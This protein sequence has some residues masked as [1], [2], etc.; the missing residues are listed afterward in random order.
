[1]KPVSKKHIVAMREQKKMT[2]LELWR[3]TMC[4]E[5][6]TSNAGKCTTPDGIIERYDTNERC[7]KCR[8]SNRRTK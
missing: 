1:M 3:D 2:W 5:K 8:Y 6:P 7:A 4:G